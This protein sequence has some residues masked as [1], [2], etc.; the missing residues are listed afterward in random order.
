MDAKRKPERVRKAPKLS[1][2]K[3]KAGK[4]I[5]GPRIS[6]KKPTDTESRIYKALRPKD[7]PTVRKQRRTTGQP[8]SRTPNPRNK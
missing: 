2:P 6:T 1:K 8:K 7:K 5:K 3:L 4:A